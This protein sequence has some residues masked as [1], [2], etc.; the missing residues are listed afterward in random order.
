[1]IQ[2]NRKDL[3]TIPTKKDD[4]IFIL[5]VP[6]STTSIILGIGIGGF[7]AGWGIFNFVEGIIH[8]HIIGLHNVNEFAMNPNT[9]N[10][11]FLESGI[12]YM[13]LGFSAIYNRE[14]YP[15]RLEQ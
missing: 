14:H 4:E 9:W 5:P 6:L 15:N 3:E 7:F 10:Y 2:E 1:M 13:A 11:S 8:H 12:I